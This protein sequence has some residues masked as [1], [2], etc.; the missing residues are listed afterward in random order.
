M[1]SLILVG[2]QGQPFPEKYGRIAR[3]SQ[4]RYK[5]RLFL[6][7]PIN[8]IL[9]WKQDAIYVFIIFVYKVEAYAIKLPQSTSTKHKSSVKVY[10][11]TASA[12]ST[13]LNTYLHNKKAYY[14]E[15]SHMAFYYVGLF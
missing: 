8:A 3:I 4:G 7:F 2:H 6:C 11:R 9:F 1:I 12:I 10:D 13:Y 14:E 15:R 5:K